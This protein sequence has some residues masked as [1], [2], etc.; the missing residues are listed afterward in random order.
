VN[1][2]TELLEKMNPLLLSINEAADLIRISPH[3]VRA[4][5]RSGLIAFTKIGTRVLIPAA[6]ISRIAA[7][8]IQTVPVT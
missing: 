1:S 2:Q 8:G 6:E 3:T 4:Y 7:E 5:V